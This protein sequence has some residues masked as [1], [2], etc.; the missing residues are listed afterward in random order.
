M[1]L[2]FPHVPLNGQWAEMG[3]GG[4]AKLKPLASQKLTFTPAFACGVPG[5]WIP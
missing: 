3:G 5:S 1:K 2:Q 4:E